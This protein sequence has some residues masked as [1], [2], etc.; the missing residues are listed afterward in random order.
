MYMYINKSLG[1]VVHP[2]NIAETGLHATINTT[3]R[4]D[5]LEKLPVARQV[6]KTSFSQ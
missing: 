4:S 3:D 6:S 5:K 1:A 2:C